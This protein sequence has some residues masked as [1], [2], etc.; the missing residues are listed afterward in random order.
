MKVTLES[1]MPM[2]TPQ[3]SGKV[4]LAVVYAQDEWRRWTQKCLHPVPWAAVVIGRDQRIPHYGRVDFDDIRDQIHIF[5]L[6]NT[7]YITGSN[8]RSVLYAVYAALRALGFAWPF[9]GDARAI[10][11]RFLTAAAFDRPIRKT[12]VLHYRGWAVEGCFDQTELHDFIAWL[13]RHNYNRVLFQYADLR[14][15]FRRKQKDLDLA[16]ITRWSQTA[17]WEVKRRGMLLHRGGHGLLPKALGIDSYGWG[18]HV[19]AAPPSVAT[20]TAQ[21]RGERK[22]FRNSPAFT[23]LC[24]SQPSVVKR[25]EQVVL[26]YVQA[27]DDIDVLDLWLADGINNWCE[28][29]GCKPHQPAD[30]YLPVVNRIA[31]AL[32]TTHPHLQVEFICYI[33]VIDPPKMP[34]QMAGNTTLLFAPWGR[35]FEHGWSEK[36][37][38]KAPYFQPQT[39]CHFTRFPTNAEYAQRFC[40]WKEK[41]PYIPGALFEYYLSPYPWRMHS[42]LSLIRVMYE[43]LQWMRAHDAHGIMSCQTPK[44]FFPDGLVI[45]CQSQWLWNPNRDFATTIAEYL[46][47]VYPGEEN[48][49]LSMYQAIDNQQR[50]YKSL[51]KEIP[52]VNRAPIERFL[53]FLDLDN[54]MQSEGA[55]AIPVYQQWLKEHQEHLFRDGDAFELKFPLIH[56]PRWQDTIAWIFPDDL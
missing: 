40:D 55:T 41:F 17:A 4:P 21:L 3:E 46:A 54:K 49:A 56:G 44:S 9:P 2:N 32:K 13:A 35:S 19:G 28:C 23:H 52:T 5:A 30:L 16:T 38:T 12:A 25:L 42:P 37:P 45:Y 31:G 36:T 7:L 48:Q 18:S 8:G 43:D 10:I 11:P 34:Y 1:I 27:N 24:L 15:F 51:V 26:D 50:N 6:T 29:D 33:S 53:E 22:L 47:Q 20:D 14:T 39:R